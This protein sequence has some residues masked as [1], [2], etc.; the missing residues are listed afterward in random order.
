MYSNNL[1][2]AGEMMSLTDSM[3][4]KYPFVSPALSDSDR[5]TVHGAMICNETITDSDN[6]N[7]N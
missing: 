5:S 1:T 2:V 6:N 3:I 4:S 7:I